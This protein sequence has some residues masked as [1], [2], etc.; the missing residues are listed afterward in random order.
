M[1]YIYIHAVLVHYMCG[2]LLVRLYVRIS[3]TTYITGFIALLHY[4]KKETDICNLTPY[5]FPVTGLNGAL[6]KTKKKLSKKYSTPRTG[7]CP[8]VYVR[9]YLSIID[10]QIQVKLTSIKHHMTVHTIPREDIL[11]M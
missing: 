11:H 10:V 2:V 6:Q 4:Q 7:Y 1:Q 3:P 5:T 9:N 8:Y